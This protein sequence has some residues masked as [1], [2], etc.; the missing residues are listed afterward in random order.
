MSKNLSFEL[1]PE[2]NARLANLCG[3][4][5]EHLH[6]LEKTFEVAI[7]FRGNHFHINGD[8]INSKK[9]MDALLSLYQ[10]T[11]EEALSSASVQLFLI[12]SMSLGDCVIVDA[13]GVK[14]TDLG[15]TADYKDEAMKW[16][17]KTRKGVISGR[18]RNQIDYLKQI[19]THDLTLR[20]R[21]FVKLRLLMRERPDFDIRSKFTEAF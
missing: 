15:N 6:Q 12:E 1:L 3:Q 21:M 18:G 16:R 10:A 4:F 20:K 7:D 5:N 19:K 13:Q 11:A 2:D 14:T 8:E 17:I 9:A